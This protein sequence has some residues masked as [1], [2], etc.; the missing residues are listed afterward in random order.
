MAHFAKISE[1]NI[2]LQVLTLND[3]DML[4]VN[5]NPSESI[6]QTYLEKHNNWPA[7]LWIQTSIN[8]FENNHRLGGTPFRGNYAGITYIWD[9]SNQIFL[10]PKPYNSW[11]KNLNKARWESPIGNAPER[12]PAEFEINSRYEW[13][14][15]NQSWYLVPASSI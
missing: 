12:T 2:V 11:I 15:N 1:N 5:N 9:V 8:T 14:E 7:N 3:K 10:P 6:G 13:N 4:D